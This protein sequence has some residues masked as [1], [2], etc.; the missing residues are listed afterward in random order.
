METGRVSELMPLS[1][2]IGEAIRGFWK[3]NTKE[4]EVAKFKGHKDLYLDGEGILRCKKC[5]EPRIF[6]LREAKRWL[7]CACRCCG[8]EDHDDFVE[9][10]AE[11]KAKS[12]L[13]GRNLKADFDKFEVS[14]ENNAIFQACLRFAMNWKKVEKQGVG[15]YLYGEKDT[16]KTYLVCCVANMLLNAGVQVLFTTVDDLLSKIRE[17]Y[18]RRS[19]EYDVIE[20]YTSAELVIFDDL[21]TERYSSR[22]SEGISFA[23]EKFFQIINTRYTREKPTIFTSNYTLDDLVRKQGLLSKT[24][25]RIGA[26]AT[27]KF[28][29]KGKP[30]RLQ[31]IEDED[32][33]F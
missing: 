5:H 18:A 3:P 14:A 10:V 33:P 31:R 1:A 19:S 25:D 8:K 21:G 28:L 6:Y 11:L 12:G 32:C 24:V 7:P 16:G 26:M 17:S 2:I 22:S 4:E 27:R 30:H 20:L 29:M 9:R 15:F 23:Q 13:E